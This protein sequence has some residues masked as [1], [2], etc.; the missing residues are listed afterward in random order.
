M[1]KLKAGLTILLVIFVVGL[2]LALAPAQAAAEEEQEG[3]GGGGPMPACLF[4]DLSGLNQIIEANGYGP[5]GDM[6][7]LM[8]G[9]GFG[10]AV[11]A[12]ASG[13]SPGCIPRRS[14]GWLIYRWH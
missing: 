8:G 6:V 5:L 2:P 3:I 12:P 9:G 14:L 11:R 10:G 7:F 13:R 1:S 4:L